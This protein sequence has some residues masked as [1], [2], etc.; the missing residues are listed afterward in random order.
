MLAAVVIAACLLPPLFAMDGPICSTFRQEVECGCSECMTW[1]VAY[2]ADWYEINR[3][4]ADGTTVN[5]GNTQW[6]NHLTVQGWI[7]PLTGVYTPEIYRTV[8]RVWC[9]AWDAPFPEAGDRY[10]YRIASCLMLDGEPACSPWSTDF[11]PANGVV[12]RAAPYACYSGGVEVE[13]YHGD[14]IAAP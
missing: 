12:Y 2:E 9:F 8:E 4:N 1:D 11:N 6:R 5:V 7:D 3:T 14:E 13:C 10:I